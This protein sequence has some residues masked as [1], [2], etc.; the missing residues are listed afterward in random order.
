MTQKRIE[1]MTLTEVE[2]ILAATKA[3]TRILTEALEKKK[4]EEYLSLCRQIAEFAL[5]LSDLTAQPVVDFKK[6]MSAKQYDQA[7]KILV[8]ALS[9]APEYAPA[10]ATKRDQEQARRKGKTS[11]EMKTETGA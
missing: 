4:Q 6:R 5:D 8:D 2:E 9:T 11:T 10:R 7:A 1:N 3:Q